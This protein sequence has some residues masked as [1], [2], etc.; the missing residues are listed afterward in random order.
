MIQIKN[1]YEDRTATVVSREVRTGRDG[2]A[3]DV[4]PGESV[5]IELDGDFQIAIS[6]RGREPGELPESQ[7]P[8]A[9]PFDNVEAEAAAEVEVEEKPEADDAAVRKEIEDM[10]TN[11]TDLTQGGKPELPA[12]NKRLDA[13]GFGPVSATRRDALMPAP[14]T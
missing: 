1:T 12:L 13:L 3:V 14:V 11:K 8:V 9:R 7:H 10:V 2:E 6:T 4:A 5:E